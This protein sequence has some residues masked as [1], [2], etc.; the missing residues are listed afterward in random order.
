MGSINR[1][2]LKM[3]GAIAI[4][5]LSG[6]ANALTVSVVDSLT[7]SNPFGLGFDGTNVFF[8]TGVG[9][10][11]IQKIDQTAAGIPII[12]SSITLSGA[13][14]GALA[15][16]GTHFVSASSGSV[17]YFNTDGSLFKQVSTPAGGGLID[18]LD[19][20]NGEVWYSPDVGAVFRLDP[21]TGAFI[22]ANPVLP[23]GG[24]FSGVERVDA[25][26]SSFLL[27]V[28]DATSPRK[29]CRT[30]LAGVFDPVNDCATLPN[31]RY[32]DLAFDGKFLY[33][34][35]VFGNRIDKIDLAAGGFIPGPGGDAPEPATLGLLGLGLG[36]LAAL[37]RRK[38]N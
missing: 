32:E 28:N 8:S 2:S 6:A 3:A 18:G 14:T 16:D 20:D 4:L 1:E 33:A 22:G 9:G 10:N 21:V 37:R 13:G 25:G 23:S 24:G 30:S 27:V 5:G 36:G 12:G 17:N 29:L 31:T 11:V 19:F 34:A 15:F 26:G 38:Y 7:T 35:D